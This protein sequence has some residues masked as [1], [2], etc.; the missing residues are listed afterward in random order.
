MGKTRLTYRDRLRHLYEDEWDDYRRG[1]RRPDQERYDRL[2]EKSFDFAVAGDNLN[3]R[4]VQTGAWLSMLLAQQR[5]ID[6]LRD[7]LND[8]EE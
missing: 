6:Q 8:L 4:D 2:T 7:R 1:L 5:E 3:P